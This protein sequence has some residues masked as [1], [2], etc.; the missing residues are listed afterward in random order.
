MLARMAIIFARPGLEQS[1]ELQKCLLRQAAQL[2]QILMVKKDIDF[3]RPP[4]P[5]VDPYLHL[6]LKQEHALVTDVNLMHWVEETKQL[7]QRFPE[8]LE[9]YKTQYLIPKLREYTPD[10][11]AV[12]DDAATAAYMA[13]SIIRSEVKAMQNNRC[14]VPMSD[15]RTVHN[16]LKGL[17]SEIVTHC[18]KVALERQ[19]NEANK[20]WGNII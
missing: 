19:R 13:G 7:I 20:Q 14:N 3:F 5:K 17:R 10:A 1:E 9:T 18:G 8:T 2:N 16:S 11:I 4:P 12:L 15:P 6:L